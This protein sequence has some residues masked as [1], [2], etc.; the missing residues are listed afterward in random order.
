MSDASRDKICQE[1]HRS[2]GWTG[3]LFNP[4][5]FLET[6]AD[7]RVVSTHSKKE[8]IFNQGDVADS[9]FYIRKGKVKVAVVS[10]Q[11]KEAVVA[12]LGP[13]EFVGEGCLIGQLKRLATATA[14]TECET[15]RVDKVR[16]PTS[17]SK[18]A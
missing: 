12:L 11:G 16:D 10:K 6:A 9:V 3:A 15:M 4:A 13:D 17:S 18:R 2:Q 1:K 7:G 5:K 14:M 8:V